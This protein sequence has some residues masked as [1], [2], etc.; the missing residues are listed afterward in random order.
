MDVNDLV[1]VYTMSNPMKA[2]MVKNLLESE[3]I[4]CFLD[5][6]NQAAEPGLIGL[7]IDVQVPAAD[8]DRARKLIL[9]NEGRHK[10]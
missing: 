10:E 3:G 6:I 4:R 7:E 2:E 1:T 9:A 5:G 8:A